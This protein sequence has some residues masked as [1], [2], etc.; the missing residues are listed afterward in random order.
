MILFNLVK[1]GG[2]VVGK[3]ENLLVKFLIALAGITIGVVVFL[4]IIA[5][6]IG[7][8][9]LEKPNRIAIISGLLSM[10]GGIAGAFSAYLIAKMQLTKQLE[11][12]DKKNREMFLAELNIKRAEDALNILFET[13]MDYFNLKGSWDGY[14]ADCNGVTENLIGIKFDKH[15]LKNEFL[16]EEVENKRDKFIYTYNKI[17]SLRPHFKELIY[18]IINEQEKFFKPLTVEVNEILSISLG[19]GKENQ[20]SNYVEFRKKWI[21]RVRNVEK[22]FDNVIELIHSQIL[23]FEEEIANIMNEFV[24]NK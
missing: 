6:Q 17:Y 13:R 10:F 14:V 19:L 18:E 21:P 5:Y 1:C 11:L 20:F 15:K 24:N 16:L 8:D 22:N 2:I 3:S 23:I 12:Q 7:V 4:T 9:D